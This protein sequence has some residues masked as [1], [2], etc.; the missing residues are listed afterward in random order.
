MKWMRMNLTKDKNLR[1]AGTV[2]SAVAALLL[3]GATGLA[4][5][6]PFQQAAVA[7]HK[8]FRINPE[9]PA[10]AVMYSCLFNP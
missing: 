6:I 2:L 4:L 10:A 3:L 5:A 1:K 8:I 7:V 9:A